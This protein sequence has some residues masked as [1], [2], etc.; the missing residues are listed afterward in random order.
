MPREGRSFP[1]HSLVFPGFSRYFAR[2]AVILPNPR[3]A[4]IFPRRACFRRDYAETGLFRAVPNYLFFSSK[5]V[6]IIALMCYSVTIL[7][8]FHQS[9]DIH[10]DF[11]H[12]LRIL[13]LYY[14]CIVR[15]ICVATGRFPG[16]FHAAQVTPVGRFF[17]PYQ[18]LKSLYFSGGHTS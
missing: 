7:R 12:V 11:F 1:F 14:V 2:F 4:A 17:I 8:N 3:Q 15:V 6:D 16:D 10:H 13:L 9:G 18:Q 5:F